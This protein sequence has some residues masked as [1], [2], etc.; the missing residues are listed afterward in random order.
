VRISIRHHLGVIPSIYRVVCPTATAGGVID[1]FR[2][3][4][5]AG[6]SLK[7]SLEIENRLFHDRCDI[8]GFV[9]MR[10]EK[11][12][13]RLRR[14]LNKKLPT[15]IE[16]SNLKAV[17]IHRKHSRECQNAKYEFDWD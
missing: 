9:E 14:S 11:H 6:C 5:P 8:I 13:K 10:V 7:L 2:T 3:L 16:F 4:S 12:R 17:N 1:G 15:T